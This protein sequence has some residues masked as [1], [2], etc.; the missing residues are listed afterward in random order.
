MNAYSKFLS[1][2]RG[3]REQQEYSRGVEKELPRLTSRYGRRG[4]YGQGVRSGIYRRGLEDFGTEAARQRGY[5]S[6]DLSN[7]LRQYD[8]QQASSLSGYEQQLT[9]LE[10][11]KAR[12]IAEDAAALMELR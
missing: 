2:T 5:M 8:L 10:A 3:Q 11:E 4:V 7:A 9:D 6:E 12:Q 1:Q